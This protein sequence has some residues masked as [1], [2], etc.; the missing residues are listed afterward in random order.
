MLCYYHMHI[1]IQY[2]F[3]SPQTLSMNI[4]ETSLQA[5]WGGLWPYQRDP[6]KLWDR[7]I[8]PYDI[9]HLKRKGFLLRAAL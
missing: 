6:A 9:S 4:D 7:G 8:I 5:L 2:L 1:V 3:I